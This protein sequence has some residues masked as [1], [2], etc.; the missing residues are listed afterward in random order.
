M[1]TYS[2]EDLAGDS[3]NR[4]LKLTLAVQNLNTVAKTGVRLVGF[5]YP[6]SL[7]WWLFI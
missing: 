6:I 1:P 3:H 4:N 5:L 7:R 2:L